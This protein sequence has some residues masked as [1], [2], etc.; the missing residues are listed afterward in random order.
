MN[1]FLAAIVGVLVGG[2]VTAGTTAIFERRREGRRCRM[3]SRLLHDD[4]RSAQADL[5]VGL[6]F[7]RWLGLNFYPHADALAPLAEAL[8]EPDWE[9]V[10]E[11]CALL[12]AVQ[13]SY[14]LRTKQGPLTAEERSSLD[15]VGTRAQKARDVL[16]AALGGPTAEGLSAAEIV[17]RAA[18]RSVGSEGEA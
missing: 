14:P 3:A 5:L 11:A 9:A 2:A 10:S 1:E 6:Q 15:M 4:L 18:W 17:R 8:E 16:S 13:R 7:G 12:R